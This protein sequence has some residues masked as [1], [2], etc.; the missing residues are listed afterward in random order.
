MSIIQSLEL[1]LECIPTKDRKAR[2]FKPEELEQA[3]ENTRAGLIQ[4]IAYLKSLEGAL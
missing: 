2:T 4:A 1:L 3:R